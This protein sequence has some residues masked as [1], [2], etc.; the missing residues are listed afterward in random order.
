MKFSNRKLLTKKVLAYSQHLSSNSNS[1]PLSKFVLHIE[2]ALSS[3]SG[4]WTDNQK[5]C[6][7]QVTV[8]FYN[9]HYK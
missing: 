7:A 6:S 3:H 9:D 2:K 5:D 4:S 8:K 1:Q